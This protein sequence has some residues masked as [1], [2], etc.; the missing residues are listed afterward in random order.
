MP[1][2]PWLRVKQWASLEG[3]IPAAEE[4]PVATSSPEK[5]KDMARSKRN[6]AKT[7]IKLPGVK[8]APPVKGPAR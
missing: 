1:V 6:V 7:S 5:K 4:P 8:R 3:L 2:L